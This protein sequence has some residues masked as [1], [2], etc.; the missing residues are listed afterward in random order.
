ML[1]Y[2]VRRV[3]AMIP[4]LFV[5]SFISFTIIQLPPGDFL[6]T[7]QAAQGSSGGGMSN[8]TAQLLRERY[9][10]DEPFMTQYVK[11][12]SG[13][14]KGDFGYSFEWSTDVWAINS[15]PIWYTDAVGRVFYC[16]HG[17]TGDPNW[18]L[19]RHPSILDWRYSAVRC[20]IPGAV[21]SRFL[22]GADLDLC[23]RH[24][25][26]LGCHRQP[27]ATIRQPAA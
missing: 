25:A 17:G 27:V 15:R 19:L 23:R 14:P 8:E 9:G 2:V 22:T 4:M 12:I 1:T 24:F 16:H 18:H 26:R 20:R 6:N 21:D 7:L 10:L 11:W 3:L 13:F 5:I